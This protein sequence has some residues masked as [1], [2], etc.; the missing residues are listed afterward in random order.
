ML[1]Q[2]IYTLLATVSFIFFLSASTCFS[3][4]FKFLITGFE[5]FGE[6]RKNPTEELVKFIN[7]SKSHL[8][9]AEIKAITFPVEYEK[10]LAIL[11]KTLNEYQPDFIISL[12][13]APGSNKIKLEAIAE[14]YSAGFSDNTGIKFHGAVIR[15]NPSQYST[16]FPVYKFK[17]V[18]LKNGIPA[19][20]SKDAGGYLCNYIFYHIMNYSQ[21]RP[22]VKA[23][24]IHV[25]DLPVHGDKG[26]WKTIQII[27]N[28]LAESSI[29]VGV[30]EFEPLKDNIKENLT[31]IERLIDDTKKF[32]IG[33]YV[34]PEMTL[35]GLL[36]NSP[37]DLLEKNP[38]LKKSNI[39]GTIKKIA[40]KYNTYIGIG[41][42]DISNNKLY[43]SYQIFDP[44]GE[45]VLLYYKNHLFGSDYNWAEAGSSYPFFSAKFGNVGVL[46]CHDVV[47]DESFEDYKTNNVD[48]LIIG[49]NWI[50]EQT[51]HRYIQKNFKKGP[52]FISDR[53]GKEG[54]TVF[55]GN[56][57]V[58]KDNHIYYPVDI[59]NKY[60]G[61]IFLHIKSF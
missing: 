29:K 35:T 34:F 38:E 50:G 5:P 27:I 6:Y 7:N 32:K 59:T 60:R 40:K 26:L 25:P 54:D 10:S 17:D 2:K 37:R 45:Q 33:I 58:I 49:T 8:N 52:V 42:A 15:G 24:F 36:Y 9:N 22:E 4:D 11:R 31:R 56:T 21:S 57:S 61:V 13:F 51:I 23:G 47:H 14:N 3:A 28:S 44:Y 43:N 53:K 16:D 20:V 39:T 30:F 46:I 55:Q 12:G 48:F 41:L 1:K 18:L 19:E